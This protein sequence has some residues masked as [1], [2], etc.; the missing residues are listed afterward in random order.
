M[1]K[2]GFHVGA[3]ALASVAIMGAAGT[4]TIGP[5]GAATPAAPATLSTVQ[6]E[7]AA[8][9]TLRVNDLNSAIATVRGTPNIGS[10]APALAAYLQADITPVQALGQKIA[11]DTTVTQTKADASTIYSNFRVLALVLPAAKVAGA[12]DEISLTFVPKLR[13]DS[14]K[15]QTRVNPSNQGIVQPLINDLNSQLSAAAGSTGALAN[16]VLSYTPSQWNANRNVLASAHTSVANANANLSKARTD[17]MEIRADLKGGIV[18]GPKA[19]APT[20]TTK[21]PRTPRTTTPTTAAPA[22]A[23]QTPVSTTPTTA[24]ATTTS[25]T[26]G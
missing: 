7:A 17:L 22:P 24:P 11:A 13:A 25:T 3:A 1:S 23:V 14:A 6:Q 9:I 19:P 8:A 2:H 10:G 26:G 5:A 16:T 15:V 12:S 18:T 20:P 4:A 21:A